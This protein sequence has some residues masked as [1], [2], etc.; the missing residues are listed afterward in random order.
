[1]L[2]CL[3]SGARPRYLDDIERALALPAQA[4]I[5]FRYDKRHITSDTL[6]ELENGTALDTDVVIAY[7]DQANPA[8]VPFVIPCRRATIREIN[9]HG[10]TVTI[11][12][13]L[14]EFA[15]AREIER[16][17]LE[18]RRHGATALPSWEDGKLRGSWCMSLADPLC[19]FAP[20]TDQAVWHSIVNQ[21]V[22][23]RDFDAKALFLKILGVKEAGRETWEQVAGS[24]AWYTFSPHK[25]YVLDIYHYHPSKEATGTRIRI[26][27]SR[28]DAVHA[29]SATSLMVDS[30]YD[31]KRF[32]LTA[33]PSVSGDRVT[34]IIE[35]LKP[36]GVVEHQFDIP[37]FVRA[38]K[39]KIAIRSCVIGLF[40]ALP[41]MIAASASGGISPL[42]VGLMLLSGLLAGLASTLLWPKS[43]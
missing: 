36:D 6:R 8:Y 15:F 29:A 25:D 43:V 4:D 1:V 23:R 40:V 16:Y 34:L 31:Q 20:A 9:D 28:E 32:R 37:A 24:N 14:R 13:Q 22:S 38:S 7:V 35:V 39:G 18:L 5:T 42:R 26:C 33:K 3:S 21:L 41:S 10:V 12:L 2:L 11:I 27:I 30:R 17:Q 19:E